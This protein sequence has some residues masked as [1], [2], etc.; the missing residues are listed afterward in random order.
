MMNSS[1]LNSISSSKRFLFQTNRGSA[2]FQIG[3]AIHPSANL[4]LL[5]KFTV[6]SVSYE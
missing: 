4:D 2:C 3:L 5:C 1:N 6:K